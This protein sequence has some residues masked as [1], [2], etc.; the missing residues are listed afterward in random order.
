MISKMAFLK[1]MFKS[2]KNKLF[3]VLLFLI[4]SVLSMYFL[5]YIPVIISYGI[6]HLLGNNDSIYII[7]LLTK[8]INDIKIYLLVICF[9]LLIVQCL[10]CLFNYFKSRF[11]DKFIQNFQYNLKHHFTSLFAAKIIY[12][13]AT[14]AS[15][16]LIHLEW[17][18]LFPSTSRNL[19]G[20]A[21]L[22][23]LCSKGKG[24]VGSQL[25]YLRCNVKHS[26][27][28]YSKQEC[29]LTLVIVSVNFMPNTLKPISVN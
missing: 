5:T 27:I 28:V 6:N 22:K 9:I 29:T 19:A 24:C 18:I 14:W 13:P 16:C 11:K 12:W 8:N 3:Y 21:C 20:F 25:S 7:D 2:L 1:I 15:S 10:V 26:A 23:N 17:I 4:F